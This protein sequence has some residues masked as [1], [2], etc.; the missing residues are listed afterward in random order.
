LRN[1][2]PPSQSSAF[3][4]RPVAAL[5]ALACVFFAALGFA[6]ETLAARGR[7][8][9]LA[10]R[11]TLVDELHTAFIGY[12]R[13]G[14]KNYSP[15]LA[16]VVDYWSRY[17]TVRSVIAS[18]LLIV[19]VTL[20]LLLWKAFLR[21]G[22]PGRARSAA[23]GSTGVLSAGLALFALVIV[24]VSIQR[25]AAP[26]FGILPLLEVGAARGGLAITVD[27]ISRQLTDSMAGSEQSRPALEAIV[28][29]YAWYHVVRVMA[30]LPITLVSV[31]AGVMFWRTRSRLRS[32]DRRTRRVFASFMVSS[33][34]LSLFFMVV[35][36]ANWG[37]AANP[38]PGLL[39]FFRGSW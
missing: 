30:L 3:P 2:R 38:E 25:A 35:F 8:S 37:T 9:D 16:R 13:S 6:P 24:T 22:A 15:D 23:L 36:A 14:E 34:L 17:N 26:F 18:V 33:A 28:G 20:S 21:G 31:G 7:D 27:Q 19:L 10:D 29:D 5:S 11:Q 12:W 1:P 32:S 39:A 4:T